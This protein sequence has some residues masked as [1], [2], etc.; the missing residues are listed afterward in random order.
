MR[1]IVE[2]DFREPDF[3]LG[4]IT[5]DSPE[6]IAL[7]TLYVGSAKKPDCDP[8]GCRQCHVNTIFQKGLEGKISPSES[9]AV[10]KDP[11]Y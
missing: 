11:M 1:L 2:R 7:N 3:V 8:H 10:L 5:K 6:K 9:P 4:N